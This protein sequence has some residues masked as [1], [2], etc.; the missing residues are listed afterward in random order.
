MFLVLWA[1][2]QPP[3]KK[4]KKNKLES[5][6]FS[7]FIPEWCFYLLVYLK[8]HRVVLEKK[9]RLIYDINEVKNTN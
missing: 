2:F 4:K 3:K 5:M 9:F 7:D 1:E 6:F 8:V